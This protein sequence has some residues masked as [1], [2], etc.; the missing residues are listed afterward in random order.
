M[1]GSRHN[2]EKSNLAYFE[3]DFEGPAW[4]FK[5]EGDTSPRGID[6]LLGGDGGASP[7]GG[8]RL[9]SAASPPSFLGA[10]QAKKTS[11]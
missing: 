8:P 2:I 11:A 5:I 4:T 9:A 6:G 10:P 1:P 3:L 7:G